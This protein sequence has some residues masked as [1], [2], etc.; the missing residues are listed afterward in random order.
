[1]YKLRQDNQPVIADCD[2]KVL[3][4]CVNQGLDMSKFSKENHFS[5]REDSP[6][7]TNEISHFLKI[8]KI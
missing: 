4:E 6:M 7:L 1:M 3:E 8:F 2:L 5:V